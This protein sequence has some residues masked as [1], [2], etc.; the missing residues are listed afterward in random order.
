M[1]HMTLKV[2]VYTL[3][4]MLAMYSSLH[5]NNNNT[6]KGGLGP[7]LTFSKTLIQLLK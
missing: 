7:V 4:V 2:Q 6:Q 1:Y 5:S 3:A